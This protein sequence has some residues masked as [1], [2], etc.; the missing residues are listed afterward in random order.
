MKEV[1]VLFSQFYRILFILTVYFC[2]IIYNIRAYAYCQGILTPV[3]GRWAGNIVSLVI[4]C[5]TLSLALFCGLP[6]FVSLIII[7]F[8]VLLQFLYLFRG[9]LI[10]FIFSS[11]T[12]LFHIMNVKMAVTSIFILIYNISSYTLFRESGLY[13]F[14]TFITLLLLLISLESF[15]R[16]IDRKMIQILMT[17]RGQLRFVTNSMMLINIYLLILSVAYNHQAYSSISGIFLLSTSLLLFGA[18]YTSFR[19]SVKMSVMMENES[20]TKRL[21]AQLKATKEDVEELQVYAFTDTLTAVHNRRFGLDELGRLLR[22]QIPFCLCYLDIDHLKY[23]ND[24]FGHD[25]GDRY[26]LDIVKV[27]T[28]SNVKG[29]SL[30]RMG[31]DE[32]MLLLPEISRKDAVNRMQQAY[33]AVSRIPSVYHPSFSYGVAEVQAD[34]GWNPSQVLRRADQEMYRFKQDRNGAV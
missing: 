9:A 18:F 3:L 13:L 26:I 25:E 5:L 14:C 20:K 29:E 11:G 33:E 12:F 21:E 30:S 17:N 31:G 19:H 10:D 6:V 27:L 15:Q 28:D 8:T 4:G 22:E 16:I 23:V 1:Y 24:T 2:F 34:T 7:Y 32:F